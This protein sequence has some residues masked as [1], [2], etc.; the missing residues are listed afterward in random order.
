MKWNGWWVRRPGDGTVNWKMYRCFFLL[1]IKKTVWVYFRANNVCHKDLVS[2]DTISPSFIRLGEL[3]LD[4]SP[5][6]KLPFA[7][8]LIV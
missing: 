1:E 3:W 8:D 5:L 7:F 6:F 4:N 2:D